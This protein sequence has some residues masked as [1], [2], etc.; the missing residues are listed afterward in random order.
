MAVNT[1]YFL[2]K[3]LQITFLKL[4]KNVENVLFAFPTQ[5]FSRKLFNIKCVKFCPMKKIKNVFFNKLIIIETALLA[6]KITHIIQK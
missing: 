6:S 5:F 4:W 1:A 2:E 3:T